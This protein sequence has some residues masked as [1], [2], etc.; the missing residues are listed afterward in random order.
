MSLVIVV[1]RILGEET[2]RPQEGKNSSMNLQFSLGR[3]FAD[4]LMPCRQYR[5]VEQI[6]REKLA[7]Y[8]PT[9]RSLPSQ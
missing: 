8:I 4:L 3:V 1:T 5:K 2:P 7:I 9:A 6:F